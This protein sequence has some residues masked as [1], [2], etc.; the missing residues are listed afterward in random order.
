MARIEGDVATLKQVVHA[1]SPLTTQTAVLAQK[2]G[3]LDKDMTHLEKSFQERLD[4]LQKAIVEDRNETVRYR[5]EREQR[6]DAARKETLALEEHRA[7][8]RREERR[9]RIGI[10]VVIGLGA[11]SSSVTLIVA[12]IG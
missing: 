1:L 11:V 12:L 4:A 10:G 5:R 7:D 6:E 2:V 8:E 3:E 9:W